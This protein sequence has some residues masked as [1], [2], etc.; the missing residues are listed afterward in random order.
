MK[1]QFETWEMNNGEVKL[2]QDQNCR[3]HKNWLKKYIIYLRV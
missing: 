2:L 3:R 1:E